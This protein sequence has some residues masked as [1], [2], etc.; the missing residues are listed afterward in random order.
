[1]ADF[2]LLC[3]QPFASLDQQFVSA[4]QR[5]PGTRIEAADALSVAVGR[6]APSM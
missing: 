5:L 3:R 2:L 1:V 4:L 6:R